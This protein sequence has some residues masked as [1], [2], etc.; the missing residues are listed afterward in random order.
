MDSSLLFASLGGSCIG[1]YP[2][3]V[4]TKPVL[5]AHI[6]PIIFQAYKSAAVGVLG[7]VLIALRILRG[8][9]PIFVF[10][11]WAICSAAA[12]IPVG[13]TTITAVSLIGVGP[14][15]DHP[16]AQGQRDP[17]CCEPFRCRVPPPATDTPSAASATLLNVV[18]THLTARYPTLSAWMQC[19]SS[20]ARPQCFRF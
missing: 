8:A 13:L 17:P 18:R 12:W 6:H 4:K 7:C 9:E 19:S 2:I 10:C 1:T 20:R 3:F 16:I 14:A 11:P 15:G 5:E